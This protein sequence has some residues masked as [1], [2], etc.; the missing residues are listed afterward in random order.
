[1]ARIEKRGN[2]YRIVVSLG[3]DDNGKQ[4][5][6]T[7]TFKPPEGTTERKAEKLAADFAR[8]FENRAKGTPA[9]NENL[10]FSELAKL[11]EEIGFLQLKPATQATYKIY[12]KKHLI[13]MF[14]TLKLSV[15]TPIIISQAFQ[16]VCTKDG[17]EDG[18]LQPITI[19]KIY[20][21]L[22]SVFRFAVTQGILKDT[23]CKNVQLPK[24]E[25]QK[26]HA[27]TLEQ[28]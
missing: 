2:S 17:G 23:P 18:K 15:F 21:T 11:Y 1:M 14:G 9:F 27:L 26:V 10:R 5:R 8:D 4:I 25:K 7:T 13:P 24:A 19:K 22:Q 12:L 28:M 20:N 16:E 3:Y 6:K